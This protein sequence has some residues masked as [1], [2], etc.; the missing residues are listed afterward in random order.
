[1]TRYTF[2]M[3]VSASTRDVKIDFRESIRKLLN[4][5]PGMLITMGV[6]ITSLMYSLFR[7][8][9]EVRQGGNAYKTGD[10]LINYEGG[11][12]GRGL[13]GQVILFISDAFGVSILW[14]SFFVQVGL[15]LIYI[16]FS[17]DII[18]RVASPYL[19]VFALS[20]LF[21]IFDFLD[22][23]GA[24]RKELLG[25]ASL[26][27]VVHSL[28]SEKAFKSKFVFSVTLFVIFIFS[29]ETGVC[30]LP[31]FLYF[32]REL[33][34]Q[35]L[36]SK[37]TI[38]ILTISY[39]CLS[40]ISV[41]GVYYFA[42][43][44]TLTISDE[45]CES[46]ISRDLNSTICEGT[47]ASITEHSINVE[48][49]LHHLWVDS[50]YGYYVPILLFSLL[51]FIVSGWLRNHKAIT[52]ILFCSTIPLY[53]FGEDYGRWIHIF[54]VFLTLAWLS[55]HSHL[56]S[57]KETSAVAKE[58]EFSKLGFYLFLLFV[59]IWRV[60]HSGEVTFY[61]VTFGF[62]ARLLSWVHLWPVA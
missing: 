8:L 28:V 60:P 21:I 50:N 25:F 44:R 56:R 49:I 20:P 48:Q 12:N 15:Y 9:M 26:I 40:L 11:Y 5:R 18:R 22:T 43:Y 13:F 58:T 4:Y 45:I 59:V 33:H 31:M 32:F 61:R 52:F 27:L 19:W 24:F 57:L 54:G 38:L 3:G 55:S 17:L 41:L 42:H 39:S 47:I 23:D 53:L 1:M 16:L 51:P 2:R 36:V 14:T 34:S 29:W 37:T 35:K 6:L 7:Q 30:F 62:L 10:W 46:L